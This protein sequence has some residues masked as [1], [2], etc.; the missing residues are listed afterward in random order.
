MLVNKDMSSTAGINDFN[1]SN[2]LSYQKWRERKLSQYPASPE[3]LVVPIENPARLS[4]SEY[5]NV[6]SALNRANLAI[7]RCQRPLA[8]KDMLRQLGSQFGLQHLDANLCADEDSITSL[9]AIET[10]RHSGYIPYTNKPLS[11]H[12]DGYYNPMDKQIRAIV[13]H[14]VIPA[15]SGGEN[16]YLDHEMLYLQLREANP[17]FISALM[18]EDA[19]SIPPNVEDGEE[20]RGETIGPVFSFDSHGHLHMRYS[21]RKRNITWRDDV[22]THA[23]TQMITELLASSPYILRYKLRAHEGVITN[24]VLHNRA[25]FEDDAQQKRLLYRA[26]YFDRARDIRNEL[27]T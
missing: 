18:Q 10:G 2:E 21:A 24:N 6:M 15:A 7:Y 12:T 1:F 19:M 4:S 13:M 11:W 8:G 16:Q 5:D 23:A 27:T 26:R 3:E 14:C 9:Q 22:L 20:I 17:D 25:A